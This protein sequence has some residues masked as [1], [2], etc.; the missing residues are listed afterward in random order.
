MKITK[1]NVSNNLNNKSVNLI[2]KSLENE[3]E[4][5]TFYTSDNIK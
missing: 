5:I 3:D 4:K 2:I 1:F